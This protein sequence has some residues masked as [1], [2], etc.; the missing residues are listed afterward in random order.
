MR[1][2]DNISI[3]NKQFDNS[4]LQAGDFN[5]EY[6]Q[7]WEEANRSLPLQCS[8]VKCAKWLKWKTSRHLLFEMRRQTNH[9]LRGYIVIKKEAVCY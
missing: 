9:Q 6:D 5:E 4:Y 3:T 2:T 1:L 7:L 8:V